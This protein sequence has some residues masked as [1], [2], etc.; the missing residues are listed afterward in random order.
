MDGAGNLSSIV[1]TNGIIIDTESPQEGIAR[2]GSIGDMDWHNSDTTI[3][4]TWNDFNDSLSGISY[5]EYAIGTNTNITQQL[6]W[7]TALRSDTMATVSIS[8]ESSRYCSSA[9]R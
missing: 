1:S 8:F 2:D 6:N 5:Y 9:T 7:T 3:T 4:F